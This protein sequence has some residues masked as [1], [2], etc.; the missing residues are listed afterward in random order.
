MTHEQF[1]FTC[2]IAFLCLVVL[3]AAASVPVLVV[4]ERRRDRDKA[5]RGPLLCKVGLH[6][7]HAHPIEVHKVT[8]DG[9]ST[10]PAGRLTHCHRDGCHWM[11][12]TRS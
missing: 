12:V 2:A 4:H 3:L 8:V 11:Q 10:F 6:D 7:R 5:P 9:V 1:V